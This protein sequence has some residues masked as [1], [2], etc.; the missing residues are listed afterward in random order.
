MAGASEDLPQLATA[1]D[2][3]GSQIAP[4]T[5]TPVDALSAT[6]TVLSVLKPATVVNHVVGVATGVSALDVVGILRKLTV[7]P[8]KVA[9]LD[10]HGAHQ[11]ARELNNQFSPLV[12]MAAAVD[13]SWVSQ[14]L[15]V[16]PDPRGQ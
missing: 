6:S 11:V 1:A 9:A 14:I 2:T 5:S 13:L 16:I 4:L 10:A 15:S 3:R 7:L 8:Q 12:K